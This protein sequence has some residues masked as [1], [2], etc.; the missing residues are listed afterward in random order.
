MSRVELIRWKPEEELRLLELWERE[1]LYREEVDLASEENYV[2]IDTPPP[3]PSGPWGVAQA[4][5]YAQID[6]VA[7]ALR[8]A[9][10]KVL[11]PFY[12]DRNGLPAEV[13][14]ERTYGV[15]AHEL[16]KTTEGRER[17]LKMVS[18][19]L[20]RNE[21][22]LVSI[23]RRL[24]C[25]FDY[26]RD[27]TDSPRYRAMTQATF[28]ELWKRG[29]IYRDTKPVQWCP[30]CRTSLAEAEID[31]VEEKGEMYYVKFGVFETGESVVIATTR[32]ELLAACGAVIYN[33]K[34]SR[35][36][37]LEGKHAVVPIYG[38]SVPV[39]PHEMA[40]V[41]YGTG[42]AMMCSYGDIRDLTFFRET[43]IEPRV[44]IEKDGTMNALAGPLAGLKV[45][46]ARRKIVEALEEKGLLAKREEIIHEIPVCW[47]CKTPVEIVHVEEFFLNQLSF[48]DRV[49]EVA[50]LMNFHPEEHKERLIQWVKSLA[51]DWP[52]SRTRYYGT[53][54]PIWTCS[55][56]GHT[57][58]PEPGA[59]VRP[60]KDPPP[61]DRCPKC[62]AS[63]ELIV[64]ESRVFDTWFDSSASV[65]YVTNWLN[66]SKAAVKALSRALRP[67]GYDII[68]TWLYYTTL[69]VWMLT[70][71]PPFK[72]VRIT[73]MGLDEKGR[74]MHKSLGNVIYPEPFIERYG[75]DAF[76]FWSAVASKLGSDYRWSEATVKS[77]LLFSTKIMNIARFVTSFEEQTQQVDLRPI[78]RAMLA[79]VAKVAREIL[80]SYQKL[81]VYEPTLKLYH[82]IW[83]VF[84]SN[85]VEMV[86]PRVYRKFAYSDSE[87]RGAIFTLYRV[88]RLS[89]KLLSPVMPFTTDYVWR[90]LENRSIARERV[91][92]REL[93]E[94]G[95]SAQL[96]ERVVEVNSAI[97][98]W[99]KERGMRLGEKIDGV[100]YISEELRDVLEDI[101]Y[102]H[103]IRDV[104]V[105]KPESWDFDLG[106]GVYL[107]LG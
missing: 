91:E 61:V 99:K 1:G 55:K 103:N 50:D 29:L 41:E 31:F 59:Y 60:W 36:T 93:D 33:P 49:L 53:E 12:A 18:D 69:R 19:L 78:D 22:A 11:V 90:A 105:G 26:W 40:K 106:G 81:D 17:F 64:G 15:V 51:M 80:E 66:N 6:M 104:A 72:W 54:V 68:R 4:A 10:Y 35:Y 43:G 87:V 48:K 107:K 79:Y 7:R 71:R 63:R 86:K 27:G 74:A 39:M 16:V 84:A 34:D 56:C 47:R 67:Q 25:L 21:A 94:F 13:A 96:M 75:A 42:L 24:G 101:K 14:A 70:D 20:D 32:P 52:I 44:V 62:N 77:G 9:G 102:F 83:D 65:L 73:G 76:R 5:H 3:Y 58:L 28:I 97:W 45:A 88:L 37:H 30:R 23:W 95:G 57:I 85:Y 38:H 2:V 8:L 82:L 100:L 98:K 89:L 92:E 46:E